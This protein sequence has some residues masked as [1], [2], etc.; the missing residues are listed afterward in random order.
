MEYADSG[1][2][3][4]K[5]LGDL[6]QKVKEYKNLNQLIP[7]E[8]VFSYFNFEDFIIFCIIVLSIS[9]YSR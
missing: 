9:L 2:C 4:D 5:L 7:E 3:Y 1:M 8:T 6:L